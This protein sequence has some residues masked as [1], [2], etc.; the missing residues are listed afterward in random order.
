MLF[1]VYLCTCVVGSGIDDDSAPI[2]SEALVIM[3]VGLN[4]QW[5]IPI[6]YFLIDGMTGS[7]RANII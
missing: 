5:K 1:Y 2:A 3:A 6:G 7:E 4:C